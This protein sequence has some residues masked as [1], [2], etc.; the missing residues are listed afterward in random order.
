MYRIFSLIYT[1]HTVGPRGLHTNTAE[2]HKYELHH[3]FHTRFWATQSLHTTEKHTHISQHSHATI[4]HCS[5]HLFIG[6]V[7]SR[8]P[9]IVVQP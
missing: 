3:R 1:T 8:H 4:S 2:A 6:H 7:V 9:L 5:G